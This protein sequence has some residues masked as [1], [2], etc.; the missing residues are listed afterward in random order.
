[1]VV[2]MSEFEESLTINAS[3]GQVWSTL[4]DI[5]AIARWNPGVKHS[6]Q[7]TVGD[8]GHGSCRRCDLGGKNYLAEEVVM[9][10][11]VSRITFRI[12]DTNLPFRSADIHFRIEPSG[13]AALVTVSPVYELKYGILG[14]ILDSLVVGPMYR[15]GMRDLLRGLKA[16]VEGDTPS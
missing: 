7:T 1:M 3:P 9:F 10:E 5:G 11:P 14:R 4:A 12:V 8:V 6:E 15:K 13:D 16:D 2:T